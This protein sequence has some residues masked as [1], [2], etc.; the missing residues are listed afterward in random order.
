[1]DNTV[2]SLTSRQKSIVIGSILG[3]G[4]LR[5]I[6]GRNDAFLEVIHSVEEKDYVDWLYDQLKDIVREPPK[7]KEGNGSRVAYRFFTRQHSDLTKLYQEFYLEGKK[8]IPNFELS[9]LI[10]A[11]WFMDDGHKGRDGYY[12]NTQNF[13][14]EDQEELISKL[15]DQFE[16]ESSL[17]KDKDY[18]RIRIWKKSRKKFKSLIEDEIIPS[19]TYKL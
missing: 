6:S 15:Y 9:P 4:Y 2:G 5:I 1:M 11:V 3:D 19:M 7:E 13:S 18:F 14:R 10:I 16:I 12:L 8:I 17:N